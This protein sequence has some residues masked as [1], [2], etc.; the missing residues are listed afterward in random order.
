M[1]PWPDQSGQPG[2]QAPAIGGVP[3]WLLE[4][5][6]QAA[7]VTIWRLRRVMRERGAKLR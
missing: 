3:S 6:G 5:L 7:L 1:S 4:G 2:T